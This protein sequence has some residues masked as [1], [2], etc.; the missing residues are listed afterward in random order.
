MTDAEKLT[1]LKTLLGPMDADEMPS[2]ELLNGFLTMAG[3][4]ILNWLYVRSEVP[5]GATIPAKYDMVHVQAC[6]AGFGQMGAENQTWHSE[7][8][9]ARTFKYGDM[10]TYIHA[11]VQPFVVVG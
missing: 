8:G 4:E 11:N 9:I 10:L 5:E 6:I 7:N 1:L 2:D 3:Y